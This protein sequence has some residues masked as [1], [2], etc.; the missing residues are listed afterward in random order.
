MPNINAFRPEVYEK[1]IYQ[2]FLYFA[3]YWAKKGQDPLFEQI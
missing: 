1:K 2:K 3:P